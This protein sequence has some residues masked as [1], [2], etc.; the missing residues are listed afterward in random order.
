MPVSIGLLTLLGWWMLGLGFGCALLLGG[1][2]APTDP[3][4]AG[5]VQVG[6]PGSEETDEVRFALTSEAGLNDAVAFPFMLLAFS[7]VGPDTTWISRWFEV[8]VVLR[9]WLAPRS[10]WRAAG[11]WA[12]CR[13][14]CPSRAAVAHRRGLRVAGGD[15]A[16]VRGV[17]ARRRLRL[18]VRVPDRD[19]LPAHGAPA[20]IS[21]D[22]IQ[23]LR[24]R[25]A[26]ADD[27]GAASA[28]GCRG[29]RAALAGCDVRRRRGAVGA[30]GGG[31]AR[32]AGLAASQDKRAV[33]VGR[34]GD[35]QR[36]RHLGD[37]VDLLP[38]ICAEPA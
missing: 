23:V 15:A 4:L 1:A 38:D 18:R 14:G 3:V 36:L 20:R 33:G 2:L 25:R 30:A 5:D 29:G 21:P 34:A 6:P 11:C 19:H 17:G 10:A 32:A 13:S 27:G 35:H 9:R 8:D 37:R 16:G 24:K 26:A 28:R 22:A 7:I 12:G 31:A